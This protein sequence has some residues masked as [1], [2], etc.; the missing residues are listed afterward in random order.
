M[1]DERF[2]FEI[3]QDSEANSFAALDPGSRLLD[4][5]QRSPV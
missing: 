4:T 2:N 1:L 3:G 5:V